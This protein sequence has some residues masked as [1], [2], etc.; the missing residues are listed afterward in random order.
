MAGTIRGG[1]LKR[2]QKLLVHGAAGGLGI[3][4]VQ[5]AK[6]KGVHVIAVLFLLRP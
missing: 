6:A 3:F 1:C 4:A 2:G 5:F